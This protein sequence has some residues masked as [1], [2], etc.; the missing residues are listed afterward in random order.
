M[1]NTL[2][3][4][5]SNNP[6]L[7]G[8]T[9]SIFNQILDNIQVPVEYIELRDLEIGDC[10]ECLACKQTY[11]CIIQDVMVPFYKHLLNANTYLIGTPRLNE[12][13]SGLLTTFM[14][15]LNPLYYKHKLRGKNLIVFTV[16]ARGVKYCGTIETI[17]NKF[18]TIHHL[19]LIGY[20]HFK[21]E[22]PGEVN[23]PEMI[24]DI[25]EI[26]NITNQQL[27]SA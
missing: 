15:R 25:V 4:N 19:N 10:T 13:P 18:A 3:I 16:G 7:N 23:A 1:P 24:G 20:Y 6:N 22:H 9:H 11:E 5:G 17:F 12:I 14:H 27:S 26:L 8:N 2:F 21:A